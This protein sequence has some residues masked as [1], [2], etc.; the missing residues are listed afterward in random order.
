MFEPD[1]VKGLKKDVI[2]LRLKA[3]EQDQLNK[4]PGEGNGSSPIFQCSEHMA[5][6]IV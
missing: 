4:K 5:A 3:W 2:R 1:M 6:P